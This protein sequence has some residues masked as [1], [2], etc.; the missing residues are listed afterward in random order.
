MAS[1]PSKSIPTSTIVRPDQI[2]QPPSTP[3]VQQKLNVKPTNPIPIPKSSH[4]S[5]AQVFVTD[6]SSLTCASPTS[7]KMSS[8]EVAKRCYEIASLGRKEVSSCAQKTNHFNC[9]ATVR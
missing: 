1:K 6:V 8:E 2:S 3:T 9:E 5:V 4:T 7:R